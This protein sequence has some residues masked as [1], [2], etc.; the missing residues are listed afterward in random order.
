MLL[1]SGGGRYSYLFVDV[2]LATGL[3]LVLVLH[4]CFMQKWFVTEPIGARPY[5]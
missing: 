4:Y 5:K 1:D 2:V 3:S